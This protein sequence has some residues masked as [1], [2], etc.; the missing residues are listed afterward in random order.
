MPLGYESNLGTPLL[1]DAGL[2]RKR[3][4][5]EKVASD[6]VDDVNTG[7]IRKTGQ[8]LA[9]M[10]RNRLDTQ[11]RGSNSLFTIADAAESYEE[12]SGKRARWLKDN[13]ENK[14]TVKQLGIRTY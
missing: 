8:G 11:G 2:W 3:L 6:A 5:E 1:G 7:K 12:A 9:G 4:L 14:K 10:L 13:D